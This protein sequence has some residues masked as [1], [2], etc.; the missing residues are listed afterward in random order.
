MF[1]FKEGVGEIKKEAVWKKL[2]PTAEVINIPKKDF[3]EPEN[4]DTEFENM[5]K[6]E[7]KK[8]GWKTLNKSTLNKIINLY[9]NRKN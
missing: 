4:E 9:K 7:R 3:S 6:E 5:T 1:K 2:K 8:A